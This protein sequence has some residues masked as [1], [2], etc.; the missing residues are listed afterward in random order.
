MS[1]ILL[2][3]SRVAKWYRTPAGLILAVSLCVAAACI[4]LGFVRLAA[5]TLLAVIGVFFPY[6][7]DRERFERQAQIDQ[8]TATL[9]ALTKPPAVDP[10]R[11]VL[12]V[13]VLND[14]D[15]IAGDLAALSAKV[16]IAHKRSLELQQR[17]GR[18]ESAAVR[19]ELA[20]P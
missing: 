1:N 18:L 12:E 5:L 17:Y 6:K 9:Q 14:I 2:W 15:R 19:S 4:A 16:D 20:E 10:E 13:R 3:L 7:I 8:L 11:S